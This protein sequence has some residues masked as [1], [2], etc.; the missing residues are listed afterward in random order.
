MFGLE[1]GT[2]NLE[3]MLWLLRRAAQN[4]D[5]NGDYSYLA[6]ARGFLQDTAEAS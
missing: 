3:G 1:G 5:A 4:F 6:E 2:P